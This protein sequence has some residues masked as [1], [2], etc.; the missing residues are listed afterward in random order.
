MNRDGVLSCIFQAESVKL[1]SKI[2]ISQNQ[3]V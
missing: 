1:M 3:D 2:I